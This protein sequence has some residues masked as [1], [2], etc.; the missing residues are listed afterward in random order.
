MKAEL[1]CNFVCL[2]RFIC[3]VA[4]FPQIANFLKWFFYFDA[5]GVDTR[6]FIPIEAIFESSIISII[7]FYLK[8]YISFGCLKNFFLILLLLLG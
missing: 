2:W 1:E 4:G 5:G 8:V 6:I 3:S 7:D